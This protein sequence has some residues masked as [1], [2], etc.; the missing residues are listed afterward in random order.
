MPRSDRRG[1]RGNATIRRNPHVEKLPPPRVPA[2][3]ARFRSRQPS[4]R[5]ATTVPIEPHQRIHPVRIERNEASARAQHAEDFG[6]ASG[7]VGEVVHDTAQQNSVEAAVRKR[8]A[9]DVA[10]DELNVRIFAAAKF[11]QFGADVEPDAIVSRPFEPMG[12]GARP[13][14]EIGDPG[15]R[16]ELAE[17][18]KRLDQSGVPLRG[19]D[20]VL[21]RPRVGVEEGDFLLFVLLHFRRRRRCHLTIKRHWVGREAVKRQQRINYKISIERGTAAIAAQHPPQF[22]SSA[23]LKM[24]PAVLVCLFGFHRVLRG[25][26]V[27]PRIYNFRY[28]DQLSTFVR[29]LVGICHQSQDILP[30]VRRM[31]KMITHC[32]VFTPQKVALMQQMAG[33]GCSAREI[34][35][36]IGSTP[37]SVRVVC[38]RQKIRLKGGQRLATGHVEQ[39]T[40]YVGLVP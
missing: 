36:A 34:A 13:A 25:W 40:E 3:A 11:D 39:L 29:V 17:T 18:H 24:L 22:F 1:R 27:V 38:S 32:R 7:R 23:P 4:Y 33:A 16:L 8:Q 21:V 37:S 14:A 19:E 6:R 30:V 10:F 5:T 12:K 20:I 15:A 35:E 26:A 28:M 9:L 31:E 2:P